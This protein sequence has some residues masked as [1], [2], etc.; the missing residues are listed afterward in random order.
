VEAQI[1]TSKDAA[2]VSRNA[3][4]VATLV[5]IGVIAVVPARRLLSLQ[6]QDVNILL[7]AALPW[8]LL[9]LPGVMRHLRIAE[10]EAF[11]VK[12]H[13]LE[14]KVEA[15]EAK[16][17]AQ[18]AELREQQRIIND[19]VVFGLAFYLVDMLR[20]FY[21]LKRA[22]GEYIFRKSPRFESNLRYL[23]DHGLIGMIEIGKLV[24]GEDILQKIELTPA[25]ILFL[26]LRDKYEGVKQPQAT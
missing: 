1:A 15:Q 22:H 8:F 26:Q 5:S 6:D 4:V 21:R 9:L 25:G 12:V 16:V 19:I 17:E 13:T 20:D 7:L 23:R 10:F 11:G 2:S 18:E 14:E 24:D 3:R